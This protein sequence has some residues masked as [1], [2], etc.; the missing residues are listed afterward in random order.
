M[1]TTDELAFFMQAIDQSGYFPVLSPVI[2]WSKLVILLVA[3]GIV[4]VVKDPAL[5]V[6]ER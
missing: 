1:A 4:S 5:I 6:W 2:F 3:K